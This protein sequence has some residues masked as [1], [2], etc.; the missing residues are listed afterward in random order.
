MMLGNEELGPTGSAAVMR[1]G[2]G[3]VRELHSQPR[4]RVAAERD[5][6]IWIRRN[7]LKMPESEK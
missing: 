3:E 1:G 6:F 2:K 4:R 7:P 5:F